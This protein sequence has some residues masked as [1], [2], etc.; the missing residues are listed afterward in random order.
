MRAD[1]LTETCD[2]SSLLQIHKLLLAILKWFPTVR[3]V[4][5]ALDECLEGPSDRDLVFNFLHDAQRQQNFRA[6]ITSRPDQDIERNIGGVCIFLHIKPEDTNADISKYVRS[7]IERGDEDAL[8][9]DI[10][11]SLRTQVP[12]KAK[13]CLIP[14][15]LSGVTRLYTHA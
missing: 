13:V 4:I 7:R 2:S 15:T 10:Q 6:I 14:T 3:L 11:E 9:L 5:D 8:D 1:S 12:A